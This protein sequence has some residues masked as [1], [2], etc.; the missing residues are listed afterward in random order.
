MIAKVS[1][2]KREETRRHAQRT[3]QGAPLWYVVERGSFPCERK[4]AK[5]SSAAA[6]LQGEQFGDELAGVG[7][8]P[9]GRLVPASRRRVV[10]VA[11]YRHVVERALQRRVCAHLEEHGIDEAQ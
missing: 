8:A 4:E 6:R 2:A 5:A 10:E 1:T 11:T 9:A 7:R 3:R